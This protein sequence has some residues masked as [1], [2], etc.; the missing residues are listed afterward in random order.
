MLF[1]TWVISDEGTIYSGLDTSAQIDYA[2]GWHGGRLVAD[3]KLYNFVN[4]LVGTSSLKWRSGVK[5]DCARVMEL[6]STAVNG[7]K[8]GFGEVV[9]LEW[10][11][12]FPML[13]SS[14]LMKQ[15]P[16]PSRYMLVTQRTIGEETVQIAND[17][18]RVW[19]YLET[20]ADRLDRRKSSIYKNR[21]RF[22]IFGIGQYS[23]ALWKVAISGF[24]KHLQFHCVG[25]FQGKPVMLDDTCYFL[26]CCTEQDG[27]I[28][29]DL[30]N[31]QIARDFF[32]TFIF[33]T[34]NV[35]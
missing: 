15:H 29:T 28:L 35:L 24:T 1:P 23:F 6:R 5:H 26:P 33:W 13:K 32:D 20:H 8:N 10:P 7:F 9:H 19:E 18:P 11:Y 30:L 22:S 25:P 2:L 17:A 31:S 34:L 4:H 27:R 16:V 21:P 12:V 14:D 3:R